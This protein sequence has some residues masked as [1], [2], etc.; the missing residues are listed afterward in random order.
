M[1]EDETEPLISDVPAIHDDEVAIDISEI[2]IP[3]DTEDDDDAN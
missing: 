2:E 1:P 3:E